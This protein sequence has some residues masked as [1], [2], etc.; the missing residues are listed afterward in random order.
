MKL[1]M[2]DGWRLRQACFDH[3]LRGLPVLVLMPHSRCNCRCVMCDIWRANANGHELTVKEFAPHIDSLM[4]LRTRWLV[5]SGGEA[6]MH[7]NLWNFCRSLQPLDAKIT[8]LSTGLLL[9]RFAN[10]T[11]N[12]CHDIIVSLDGNPKIHDQIRN[13]PRAYT[14]LAEGVQAIHDIESDFPVT[15]RCVIQKQNFRNLMQI[16][17]TAEDLSLTQISFLVADVSTQAFNRPEGWPD[18]KIQSVALDGDEASELEQLLVDNRNTLEAGHKRGLIA[19]SFP[20]L[21]QMAMY[22]QALNNRAP[23]PKI[24]CNAPWVSAVVEADGEIRPC[25]FHPPYGNLRDADLM[26]ILNSKRA[27]DFRRSLDVSSNSICQRCVCSLSL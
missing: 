26:S 2:S 24:R 19:E 20:K 18:Q 11:V 13:I 8:L 14:R 25:F 6:L 22:Y 5:L 16:I 4:K 15:G 1:K 23:F 9:K 7:T 21:R 3:V 17:S 10:E 27:I 12:H